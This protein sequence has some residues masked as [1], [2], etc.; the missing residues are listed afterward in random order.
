M[1][2]TS[3]LTLLSDVSCYTASR[4]LAKVALYAVLKIGP[5]KDSLTEL[6]A[7]IAHTAPEDR[8][9]NVAA[10]WSDMT[11][12]PPDSIN[13]VASSSKHKIED[14]YPYRPDEAIARQSR[15]PEATLAE[16]QAVFWKYSADIFLALG[17]FSL[18][19]GTFSFVCSCFVF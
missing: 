18:T 3:W 11:G 15:T 9:P 2:A 19:V 10:F 4:H 5:G 1:K 8:D 7:Y 6:E 16:G 17:N 13:A 12:N 14:L